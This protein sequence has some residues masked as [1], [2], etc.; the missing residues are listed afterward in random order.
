MNVNNF[1]TCYH[2]VIKLKAH[3]DI[4]GKVLKTDSPT[5]QVRAPEDQT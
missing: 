1:G 2:I 4:E 5:I 3:P